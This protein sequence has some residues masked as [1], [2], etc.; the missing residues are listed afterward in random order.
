[1]SFLLQTSQFILAWVR[2]RNMLDCIP[3]AWCTVINEK[4]K[5]EHNVEIKT[6]RKA[7]TAR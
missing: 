4:K 1:M 2:H 7:Y 5:H 6:S 3:M